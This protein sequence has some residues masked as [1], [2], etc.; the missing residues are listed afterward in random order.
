MLEEMAKVGDESIVSWQPNG[1]SFR[2]HLPDV[3]ARTVMPRYFT[4]Q[5]KYKSF[6]RQLHMYGF[7][8]ITK[9]MDRGAYF[10][11]MFIRNKK[12]MSLQMSCCRKIRSKK[13]AAVDP[14][15]D[16]SE[17]DVVHYQNQDGR[18]LTNVLQPDP[19]L[20]AYVTTTEMNRGY[21][22]RSPTS[23][24]YTSTGSSGHH[25]NEEDLLVNS[26]LLFN[27]E[28]SGGPS[29]SHQLIGSDIGFEHVDWIEQAEETQ[30]ILSADEGL[31]SPHHGYDS[32][33]I[34][35]GHEDS[36]V[37]VCVVN[38]QKQ[39]D[40]GLFAGK[41]FF[42]VVEWEQATPMVEDFSAVISN[43]DEERQ[44]CTAS[45]SA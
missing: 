27:H 38:H 44:W 24:L 34:E 16:S 30:T 15:F 32:S 13:Y 43:I 45:M 29:P 19:V 3:F 40:E 17:T 33:L 42:S 28:V 5:T 12:S 20:Q 26:A 41:R 36:A 4:K 7:H 10:H 22:K 31:T 9:G 37:L 23:A 2:V 35:K 18:N 39:G 6:L 14:D 1:M 25:P 21:S 11:S 8:R